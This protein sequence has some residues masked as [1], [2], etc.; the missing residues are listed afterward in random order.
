VIFFGDWTINHAA[1]NLT[2]NGTDF[3]ASSFC[4]G[5]RR[6]NIIRNRLESD[7][8]LLL[9]TGYDWIFEQPLHVDGFKSHRILLMAYIAETLSD[10]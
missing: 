3:I 7:C 5:K 6:D 2:L 9:V 10:V 4:L 8:I 1:I